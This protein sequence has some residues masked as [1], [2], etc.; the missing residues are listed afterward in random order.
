MRQPP[1]NPD[2]ADFAPIADSLTEYDME[3]LVTYIRLLDANTDGVAWTETAR[4]VLHIDPDRE[5]DRAHRSWESSPRPRAVDDGGRL[6][7]PPAPR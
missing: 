6:P 7:A 4:T 1:P 2:C 3:H 5:R